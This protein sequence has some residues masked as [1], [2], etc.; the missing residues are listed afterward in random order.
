MDS[1]D[2]SQASDLTVSTSVYSAI[3]LTLDICL[4]DSLCQLQD[5]EVDDNV[6]DGIPD[7]SG[8][9]RSWPLG[10]LM[11]EPAAFG[12]WGIERYRD[13]NLLK[14]RKK[15]RKRT[16]TTGKWGCPRREGVM[17]KSEGETGVSFEMPAGIFRDFKRVMQGQG[18][19]VCCQDGQPGCAPLGPTQWKEG[20]TPSSCMTWHPHAQFLLKA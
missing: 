15:R 13:R 9:E 3:S 18:T 14:E 2:Q 6:G 16:H 7:R 20:T 10:V 17:G 1:I 19:G 11:V 12:G 4:R 8:A 5:L